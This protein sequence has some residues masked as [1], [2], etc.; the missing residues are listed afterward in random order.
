MIRWRGLEGHV[1]RMEKRNA[2]KDLGGKPKGMSLLGTPNS[3]RQDSTRMYLK[4]MKLQVV[5][6]IHVDRDRNKC[7]A[8][9]NTVM[10]LR[11]ICLPV[12]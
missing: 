8:I 9:V 10:N 5:V 2:Y 11:R 4:E 1:A 12:E 3:G 6:K 7:R